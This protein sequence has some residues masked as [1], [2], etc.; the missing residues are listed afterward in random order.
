ME[1]MPEQLDTESV[2][3]ISQITSN[4]NLIFLDSQM[5]KAIDGKSGIDFSLLSMA[6]TAMELKLLEYNII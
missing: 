1:D 3:S 5:Q 6:N 2:N 4:N